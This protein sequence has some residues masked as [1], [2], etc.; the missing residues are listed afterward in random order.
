MAVREAEDSIYVEF[1]T[2]VD[3]RSSYRINIHFSKI[4]FVFGSGE[5]A[6]QFKLNLKTFEVMHGL[7][8]VTRLVP[9]K[10]A[11]AI[12]INKEELDDPE[13]DGGFLIQLVL[14]LISFYITNLARQLPFPNDEDNLF[15]SRLE[16]IG[17]DQDRVFIL[18]ELTI[19]LSDLLCEFK[20]KL[21]S[22]KRT[23]RARSSED[24]KNEADSLLRMSDN[25]LEVCKVYLDFVHPI[26]L[27]IQRHGI[28][29]ESQIE[30][31][32]TKIVAMLI[33]KKNTL[34]GEF[35]CLTG[36]RARED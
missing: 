21:L 9:D 26:Y 3:S 6:W 13:D 8:R 2:S 5:K 15:D 31:L 24:L 1:L 32:K 10:L 22:F 36:R 7:S 14:D 20:D 27:N 28:F 17:E 25:I 33:E 18:P 11:T 34:Q 19:E 16:N 35:D 23:L 12:A 4:Y 29:E 30:A